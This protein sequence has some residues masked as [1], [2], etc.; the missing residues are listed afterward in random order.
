MYV[1]THFILYYSTTVGQVYG[2]SSFVQLV[3]LVYTVTT[4]KDGRCRRLIDRD[5][6]VQP[7]LLLFSSLEQDHSFDK[8][9][10]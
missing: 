3:L 10:Q 2:P 6:I 7:S 5:P 9:F 4:R 1:H 8:R